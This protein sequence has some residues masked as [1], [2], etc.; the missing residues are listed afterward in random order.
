MSTITN[1][2]SSLDITA[3]RVLDMLDSWSE[4]MDGH[5]TQKRAAVR[6]PFR[7][8]MTVFVPEEEGAVGEADDTAIIEVWTRNISKNGICF[9]YPEV[10][11]SDTIIVCLQVG[12]GPANYF[13]AE[14]V[15]NRQTHENFWEYGVI[16]KERAHM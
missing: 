2:N 13:H 12:G 9:I 16:F 11:K 5:Q 1:Q 14:I 8:K 15:R 4:R 7:S 3:N 10:I 6:K